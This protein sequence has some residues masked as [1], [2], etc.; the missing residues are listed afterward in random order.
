MEV[1]PFLIAASDGQK[2][3][4]GRRPLGIAHTGLVDRHGG[5]VHCRSCRLGRHQH[6]GAHVFHRL[7][8]PDR[9]PE[10]LPLLGVG[11][12]Q[13]HGP[14]GQTHEEGTPEDPLSAP[15]VPRLLGP[16]DRSTFGKPV[17]AP[18]G[19]QRVE[20]AAE[21]HGVDLGRVH[22]R[23]PVIGHH[24][25]D[26]E[27]RE[28]SDECRDEGLGSR[29]H[30]TSH[31]TDDRFAVGRA[32]DDCRRQMGRQNRPRNEGPPELFEDDRRRSHTE[33]HPTGG[34][35]DLKREHPGV[36]QLAP[37]LGVEVPARTFGGPQPLQ[38][39]AARAERP[40]GVGQGRLVIGELEIHVNPSTSLPLRE[41]EDP[42]GDDVALDLRGPRRDGPGETMDPGVHGVGVPDRS[43]A[44]EALE[45]VPGQSGSAR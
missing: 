22:R 38:G 26:A 28:V 20:R 9:L 10:L 31:G 1:F 7:E 41:S 6:V 16:A 13:V 33:A 40:D 42:L 32:V 4:A 21:G 35:A 2:S 44:V 43:G 5:G 29:R 3:R 25:Q 23:Q 24:H 39:E 30:R 12:R 37:G 15:P 18:H 19:G 14:G 17:D 36:G 8:G 27:R 11:D 45:L 34:F